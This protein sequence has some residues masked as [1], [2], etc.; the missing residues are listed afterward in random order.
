MPIPT[1]GQTIPDFTLP[2]QH[3]KP[4]RLSDQH[5]RGP[6]VVFFY[7][8]DE[9]AGCIA[10][11]CAFRDE[12]QSFLEA[13]ATVIGISS[14]S[15]ASHAKFAANHRLPY[16]LLSDRGGALRKTWQVP[17]TL[18]LIP[19]RV[20]YVIDKGGSLLHL[21]S[22]QLQAKKHVHEALE[23]VRKAKS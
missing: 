5:G 15:E 12:H 16:T 7:P 10:E 9:T 22:S 8:K 6:V 3:G 2:D 20:T 14:D 1:I 13:G 18:G 23:A 19:G 21:F 17:K 11:A 4:V